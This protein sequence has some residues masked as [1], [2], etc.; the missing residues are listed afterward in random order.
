MVLAAPLVLGAIV[1]EFVLHIGGTVEIGELQ[2]F[3]GLHQL[4]RHH[5]RLALPDL[6][7]LGQRHFGLRGL[8]RFLLFRLHH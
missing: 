4:R 3:D 7:S 8:V 5:Q 6:E 2:Q 1:L